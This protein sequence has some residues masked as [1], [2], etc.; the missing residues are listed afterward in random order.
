[1]PRLLLRLRGVPP[2]EADEIRELLRS[3]SIDFY[4]TSA[5]NWGI[6]MPAMWLRD[7]SQQQRAVELLQAYQ[8]ER[9]QRLQN[10]YAQR[11]ARGEQRTL[12]DIFREDPLRMILYLAAVAA[13]LYISLVP[14]FELGEP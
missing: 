14:F 4:E 7:G 3:N 5:G 9:T 11:K 8:Q 2:D 10:E 6:S 1:M 13:I 12:Y